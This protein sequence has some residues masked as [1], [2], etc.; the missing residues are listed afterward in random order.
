MESHNRVGKNNFPYNEQAMGSKHSLK[1]THPRR[2]KAPG[3]VLRPV[4]LGPFFEGVG[5]PSIG[6]AKDGAKK[7]R[8]D[9]APDLFDLWEPKTPWK[10]PASPPRKSRPTPAAAIS[11][12]A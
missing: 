8:T 9:P 2:L 7:V 10:N 4:R 1:K 5:L 11:G 6:S 12:P 3:S